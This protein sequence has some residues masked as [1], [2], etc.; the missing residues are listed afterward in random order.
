MFDFS[1]GRPTIATT[2]GIFFKKDNGD[3]SYNLLSR[4]PPQQATTGGIFFKKDNGDNSYN[5]LGRQADHSHHRQH[6]F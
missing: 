6:F 3:N 1:A 4:H 5:L 2:G